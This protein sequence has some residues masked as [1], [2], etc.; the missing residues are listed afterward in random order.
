VRVE[1]IGQIIL[2][3]VSKDGLGAGLAC[4]LSRQNS[5]S[6][7]SIGTDTHANFNT[8]PP[9]SF[10]DKPHTRQPSR[11]IRKLQHHPASI[12]NESDPPN[13]EPTPARLL[14]TRTRTA[15]RAAFS[16]RLCGGT[17][18]LHWFWAGSEVFCRRFVSAHIKQSQSRATQSR[19]DQGV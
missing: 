19:D 1:K 14:V 15:R 7:L 6:R 16:L 8:F 17:S 4:W 2:W 3:P 13:L 10:S 12:R 9:L 11:C 18:A 5:V